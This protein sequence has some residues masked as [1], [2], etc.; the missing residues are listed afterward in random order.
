VSRVGGPIRAAVA[1]LREALANEGIRRL[2]LNWLLGIAADAA[3]LVLLLVVVYERDGAVAT[4]ILGAVRMVPAV[5]AGMLAGSIL[6]RVRGDRLLVAIG[7]IRALSAVLAAFVIA[8]NGP[9]I[10]LFGLAAIAAAAGAPVRPI[11]ATL[12]PALAR[13]PGELVASNMAW[14]VAEGIGAFGGPFVAGLLIA[15][16]QDTAVAIVAAAVFGVTVLVVAGL[17]FEQAADATGGG[18]AERQRGGLRLLE[19]LRTLARRPVPRWSMVTVYGQ[20]LTRGLLNTLIVVAAIELLGMGEGGVGI[21]TAAL[22]IGGLFGAIFAVS[23]TRTDAL[24]RTACAALAYWGAPIAVIGLLP[25]AG[26]AI[27]AMVVIGLANATYD[28]A[29][30]TIFQRGCSNEERAPVFS[31][32][33]GVAGLGSV[34][35]SLL[36]PVLLVAFGAQGALVIAGA[37]LPIVALIVYGMIGR[38]RQISVVDEATVQLLREVP[39]FAELPLT[40]VERVAAGMRRVEAPAG[41]VM[42]REG[43]VGDEFIV[44][45]GG[46]VDV[47]VGGQHVHRLGHGAGIGE[48]A[49]VRSSSRTATVTA[50]SDVIAFSVDCRTFLAAVSGPAAAAVTE[51]IADANLARAATTG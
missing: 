39:I 33:E 37:F 45:D 49:L 1:S 27:A 44:I 23:L 21:L 18:G 11:Q 7:A 35:G 51:H 19:G 46:E 40:A 25:N 30:F 24:V 50:A 5:L 17:R 22:G 13:S 8:T 48:I 15:A 16:H 28:I 2:E 10:A 6:E 29:V 3:L 20:V 12:M 9:T 34:S 36:A 47:S 14:T 26:V 32:F 42:L 38:I 43:E 41:T 4:G 31:V